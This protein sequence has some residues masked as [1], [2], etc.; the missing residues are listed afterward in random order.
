MKSWPKRTVTVPEYDWN[1]EFYDP[2]IAELNELDEAR[3]TNDNDKVKEIVS[4]LIISWDAVD[5]KN[6]PLKLEAGSFDQLPP[7]VLGTLVKGIIEH[8]S[9]DPNAPVSM[10]TSPPVP[11]AKE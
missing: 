1:I 5:R 6:E 4:R 10:P 7:A 8:M 9:A 2:T 3:K 11:E